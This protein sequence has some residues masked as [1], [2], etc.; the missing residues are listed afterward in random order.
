M[1]S[2]AYTNCNTS[3]YHVVASSQWWHL[4]KLQV[5]RVGLHLCI[6]WV[7]I[8]RVCVDMETETLLVKSVHAQPLKN[9]CHITLQ[10]KTADTIA[11]THTHRVSINTAAAISKCLFL[12]ILL[13]SKPLGLSLSHT[14][15][16]NTHRFISM[17][18]GGEDSVVWRCCRVAPVY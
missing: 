18:I 10:G 17:L 8:T 11:S 15:T 13:H 2:D 4:T 5:W 16:Q 9:K 3:I 6:W 1:K 14:H 7:T 12:F